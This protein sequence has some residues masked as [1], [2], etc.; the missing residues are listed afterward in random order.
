MSKRERKSRH[1]AAASYLR[2]VVDEDEIV[3]VVASHYLDAYLA[4][5]TTRTRGRSRPTRSRRS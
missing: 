3:E 5:P 2:S 1:L 4:A